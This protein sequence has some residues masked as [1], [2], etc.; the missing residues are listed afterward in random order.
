M[1]NPYILQL[2]KNLA[3]HFAGSGI[4]CV[5]YDHISTIRLI[6]PTNMNLKAFSG[7]FYTE[8]EKLPEIEF[9]REMV[10]FWLCQAET[11]DFYIKII[12]PTKQAELDWSVIGTG[13]NTWFPN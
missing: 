4:E 2:I 6:L 3:K 12:N 10:K 11:A 5:Y 7:S 9:D 8:L 13:P 1:E